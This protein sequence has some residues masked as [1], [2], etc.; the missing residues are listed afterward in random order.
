VYRF[1]IV[2]WLV[3]QL[4][5]ESLVTSPVKE[6]NTIVRRAILIRN[7]IIQGFIHRGKKKE[8]IQGIHKRMMRF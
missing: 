8:D 6:G 4:C 2:V 5:I 7:Y 1:D 3:S